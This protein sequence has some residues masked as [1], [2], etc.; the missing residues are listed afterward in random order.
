MSVDT[1]RSRFR[2]LVIVAAGLFG[3]AVLAIGLTVWWLR[4]DAIDDATKDSDHLAIVLAEQT[5][6]AV[7]SID[8]VLEGI[9]GR[10][11][12]LGA[13]TQ[14][15]FGHLQQD[16][17]TYSSLTDSLS[18]LSQAALIAL[19]DKN[20][21]VVI[22]T[23]K[24]PTPTIDLTNRDYYPHFKNN[25]DKRIYVGKPVADHITGLETIFFGKRINDSN[26]AFLG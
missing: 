24:W 4:L 6:R 13:K 20:G 2:H 8:L 5:N 12:N 11:E 23:Q 10:L 3:A 7:Q 16:K 14:D 26:N 18:H 21:R 25:D 19:I 22:T 1:H 9:Q 15:N 17:T